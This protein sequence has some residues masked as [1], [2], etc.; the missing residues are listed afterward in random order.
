MRVAVTGASGYLGSRIC[1]RLAGV[2]RVVRL[3]RS[4]PAE[5]FTLA[6]GAEAGIFRDNSVTALVHCAWDFSL[7]TR[8]DLVA[9]NVQGSIRLM[10]QARAEG[11]QTIV[12]I[13]TIS[14]FPGCRSDYGRAKLAVEDAA[15]RLGAL[16]VRPGLVFGDQPGGV[17]GALNTMVRR[18]PVVPLI[19]N[20]R[21]VLYPAHEDDVA[22]LIRRLVVRPALAAPGEPVIAAHERGWTLRQVLLELAA[23]QRRSIAV[24]PVPWRSVWLP[25]KAAEMVG[26]RVPFRSDSV[27]SVLNQDPSPD[28]APTRSVGVPF[29][30]FARST[31]S[32]ESFHVR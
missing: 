25:L 17:V 30:D 19:G 11:A 1:K 29:R 13:S 3:G 4:A 9:R 32:G 26:L 28:F 18:L 5:R 12:F 21:Q 14:A 31:T 23:R 20:G 16:V 10:E 15:H 27:V 22:A 2:G 24:V 6:G 8:A 7:H